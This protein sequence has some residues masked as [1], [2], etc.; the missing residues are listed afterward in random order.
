[1]RRSDN[2][3]I[4]DNLQKPNVNRS[5]AIDLRRA[6]CVLIAVHHILFIEG[7]GHLVILS[8]DAFN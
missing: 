3:V 4:L 1:M 2:F 7:G 6:K 5:A 8:L